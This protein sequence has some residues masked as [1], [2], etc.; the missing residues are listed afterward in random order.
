MFSRVSV[1]VCVS[2]ADEFSFI[3]VDFEKA[4][5]HPDGDSKYTVVDTDVELR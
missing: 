1:C 3:H 2:V 4:M 5:G